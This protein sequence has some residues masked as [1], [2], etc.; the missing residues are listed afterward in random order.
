MSLNATLKL[1]IF[2][3]GRTQTE[4]AKQTGIDETRLSRIVRGHVE[5]SEDEQKLIAKA[6][7]QPASSLFAQAS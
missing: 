4:I 7:K 1:A 5:A 3:S 6:L 2:Q